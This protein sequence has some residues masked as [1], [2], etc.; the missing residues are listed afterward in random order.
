MPT[1]N[2][3]DTI[4]RQSHNLLSLSLSLSLCHWRMAQILFASY[5]LSLF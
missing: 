1:A 2:D 4:E 5:S 3:H